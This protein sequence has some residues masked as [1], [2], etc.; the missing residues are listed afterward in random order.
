MQDFIRSTLDSIHSLEDKTALK[1]AL[2]DVF[3]ALY[4][5]SERKYAALEERVRAELPLIYEPYT[6]YSTVLGRT[7]LDS[8][9]PYL[10]PMIPSEAEEPS[11]SVDGLAGA[12]A[13]N[14]QPVIGT[15]FYEADYLKCRR[16][17]LDHQI[18]DGAFYIDAEW[19]PFKFRLKPVKRYMALVETL[20]SIFLRNDVPWTTVNCAYL[21][22]FFDIALV[23]LPNI[24][25]CGDITRGNI[26]LSFPPYSKSIKQDLIPVWNIDKHRVKGDDFPVPA[27]D[28]VNYEY[29][30]HTNRLGSENG[31]LMDY[32]SAYIQSSRREEG[33][34]IAASPVQRGL[35]WD[36]FRFRQRQDRPVDTYLYPVLSNKRDDCFSTRLTAAYGVQVKTRA[37]LRKLLSS[38]E[39]T[40]SI[41]PE[42]MNLVNDKISGETYSMNPF[43]I[44]E[45]RDPEFQRTLVLGFRAKERNDFLKHDLASFLVSQAQL[46][47][48]E[49]NCVGT[50]L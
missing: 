11:F 15:V 41:E 27:L 47:Y 3:L 42:S 44:D 22:K 19:Y 13:E 18:F 40:K 50:L 7:Q 4:E 21:N 30:F 38:F 31:F 14:E 25:P 16:L 24:P 33:I 12:L 48:P 20:Y 45:L 26:Y 46:V 39:S 9:H 8:G 1:D 43:I 29:H 49:Y 35:T 2:N 6:I 23:N 5:E 10:S 36:M 32:D 37:E 17:D 28:K 34:V